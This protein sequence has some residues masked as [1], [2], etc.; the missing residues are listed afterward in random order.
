[1]TAG[2][3]GNRY[4]ILRVAKL[5][6]KGGLSAALRH[7]LRERDTPNAHNER[8]HENTGFKGAANVQRGLQAW[9]QRAP[10]KTR[11]KAVLAL[12]YFV[13]RSPERMNTMSRA[14]QDAYFAKALQSV[15]TRHGA[16]N[17]LSAIVHRDEITPHMQ[18]L[19]IPLD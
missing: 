17:V 2:G 16:E 3:P 13:G 10:E 15:E 19:V 9:Q 7:S 6:T 14:E 4:A 1:K 18:L 5:K 11:T 8:L 12:E